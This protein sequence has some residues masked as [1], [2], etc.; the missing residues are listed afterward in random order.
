[1]TV[2]WWHLLVLLVVVVQFLGANCR[3]KSSVQI[4]GANCR[5]KSLVQILGVNCWCNPGCKLHECWDVF[6]LK[7]GLVGSCLYSCFVEWI[8]CLMFCYMLSLYNVP[9]ISWTFKNKGCWI[10]LT[11]K[12][13][14]SKTN[15]ARGQSDQCRSSHSLRILVYMINKILNYYWILPSS[16]YPFPCSVFGLVKS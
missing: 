13:I 9:S 2:V 4:R 11:D 3:C 8:S 6:K 16:V 15:H 1:M 14:Y 5:C 10:V 7:A 12:I